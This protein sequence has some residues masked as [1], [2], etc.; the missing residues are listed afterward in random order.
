MFRTI[1]LVVILQNPADLVTINTKHSTLT[2]NPPENTEACQLILN[3]FL[4]P[5]LMLV[6]LSAFYSYYSTILFSFE[7]FTMYPGAKGLNVES[8]A[9]KR[10]LVFWGSM[11][12]GEVH[13][14]GAHKIRA[15]KYETLTNTHI[16]CKRCHI[17][18]HKASF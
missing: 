17:R 14:Q 9:V 16:M 4:A 12:S 2:L 10:R 7:I 1:Q 13:M 18:T 5:L 3:A 15:P 8:T 6:L 11:C